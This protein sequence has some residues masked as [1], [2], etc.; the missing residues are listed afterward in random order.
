MNIIIKEEK[1]QKVV[2]EQHVYCDKCNE[3]II[4]D[5]FDSFECKIMYREG[6]SYP[7]GGSGEKQEVDLCKVCASKLIQLLVANK[8]RINKSEWD[9]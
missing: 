9:Y 6:S 5:N 8:Y 2:V 7:E 1:L 3:E 4:N